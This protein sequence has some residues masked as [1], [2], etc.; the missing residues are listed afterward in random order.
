[1]KGGF[2]QFNGKFFRESDPL[3]TGADLIR[4]NSGICESFRAENNRVVFARE[5]FNFLI[6]SLSAIEIPTPADWD[7]PRFQKVTT[8][9]ATPSSPALIRGF[10]RTDTLA[11][12][13]CYPDPIISQTGVVAY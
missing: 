3:F 2:N 12:T 4:L 9:L 8:V 10:R 13:V 1:M 5:N 7:F 11:T 6:D